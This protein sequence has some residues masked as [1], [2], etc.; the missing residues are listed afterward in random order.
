[1]GYCSRIPKVRLY[2]EKTPGKK[3]LYPMMEDPK[4]CLMEAEDE[5]GTGTGGF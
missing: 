3:V 5:S 2:G 1:M 4:I